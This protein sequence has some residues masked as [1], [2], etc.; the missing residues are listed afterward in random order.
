MALL[1][2]HVDGAVVVADDGRVLL[3]NPAANEL[4]GREDLEGD[5]VHIPAIPGPRGADLLV[6]RPDG[7]H[8][9][10]EVRSGPVTWQGSAATLLALRDVTE[11]SQAEESSRHRLFGERLEAISRLA[12]GVAGAVNEPLDQV[13]QTLSRIDSLLVHL[14]AAFRVM[15]EG[16]TRSETSLLEEL[17]DMLVGSE[18]SLARIRGLLRHLRTFTPIDPDEVQLVDINDVASAAIDLVGD[19]LSPMAQ[20]RVEL[21]HVPP[22]LG[23]RGRLCQ[24]VSCLLANATQ[25]I[26]AGEPA[27]NEIRLST[28]HTGGTVVLRVQDTGRGMGDQELAQIFEP[29]YSTRAGDDHAGLGLSICADILRQH[30][31]DIEV[32]TEVGI[33]TCIALVLPEDTGLTP[34]T[35]KIL[36]AGSD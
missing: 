4:F 32:T 26:R 10:A 30:G 23:H 3:A 6:A 25:A 1:H 18:G 11:R 14:Q 27:Q 15:P 29:F 13:Q 35:G 24:A 20:L 2:E 5:R 16:A 19:R 17:R 31:G 28:E 33:G 21:G 8:R 22:I 7:T 36:S 34:A 12:T 9:V